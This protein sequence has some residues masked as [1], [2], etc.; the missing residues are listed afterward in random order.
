MSETGYSYGVPEMYSFEGEPMFFVE[1][2][3]IGVLSEKNSIEKMVDEVIGFIESS[4]VSSAVTFAEEG[5]KKAS[6]KLALAKLEKGYLVT[7]NGNITRKP[8]SVRE[9]T[10][11]IGSKQTTYYRASHTGTFKK[12]ETTKG[13]SQLPAMQKHMEG[14]SMLYFIK[15]SAKMFGDFSS[16]V[17]LAKVG[18]DVNAVAADAMALA[19]ASTPAIGLLLSIFGKLTLDVLVSPIYEQLELMKNDEFNMLKTHKHQGISKLHRYLLARKKITTLLDDISVEYISY[20]SMQKILNGT[21][22]KRKDIE[23][24]YDQV[25]VLFLNNKDFTI[26]DSF[27]IN[28]EKK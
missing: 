25:A 1:I 6:K 15:N 22:K 12:G 17:D 9:Y 19:V 23:Y 3:E 18:K 27:F 14:S 4:I 20:E 28:T 16:L 11:Y 26:I 10:E 2:G 13:L 5:S 21:V 7:N 8:N 24:A